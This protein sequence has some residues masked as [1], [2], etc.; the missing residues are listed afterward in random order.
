M[1]NP[2]VSTQPSVILSKEKRGEVILNGEAQ[3]VDKNPH[4]VK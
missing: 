1:T 3:Y 2:D 4:D